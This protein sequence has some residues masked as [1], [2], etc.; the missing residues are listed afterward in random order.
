MLRSNSDANERCNSDWPLRRSL[1]I[2]HVGIAYEPARNYGG[3]IRSLKALC[4]GLNLLGH[5]CTVCV[6]DSDGKSNIQV[7]TNQ[8]IVKKEATVRYF[9][10]PKWLYYGYSPDMQAWLRAH[11]TDFDVVHVSGVWSFPER[12]A[13]KA[14]RQNKIPYII[15]PRGSFDVN[16]VRRRLML[17]KFTYT[18]LVARKTFTGAAAI[19][20]TTESEAR[21]SILRRLCRKSF[22]VPNASTFLSDGTADQA[23]S[24]NQPVG[25]PY[26]LFV[27]RLTWKKQLNKLIEAFAILSSRYD[28]YHL[29][30]VGPDDEGVGKSLRRIAEKS[31][32]SKRVA[33]LGPKF[34]DELLDLYRSAAV[35][36]LPSISENFGHSAVEAIGL[37]TPA[38]LSSSLDLLDFEAIQSIVATCD[39]TAT[40]ISDAIESVLG[41]LVFWKAQANRGASRVRELFDVKSVASKMEAEYLGCLTKTTGRLGR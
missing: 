20:Y 23:G 26:V 8:P 1:K 24:A 27:G 31:G 15:S 3:P 12:Y 34:G 36:I 33:Y 22:V 14:A 2:L 38:I 21:K 16:L 19:H 35:F 17:S 28:E 37:G 10:S 30:L 11:V 6:T 9:R 41:N 32:V 13:S 7:D 29:V 4:E 40:S 39:S 25:K 5:A 18:H